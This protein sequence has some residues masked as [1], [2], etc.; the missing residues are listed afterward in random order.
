VQDLDRPGA[1]HEQAHRDSDEGGEASD[2]H[3]E[4]R[5]SE[6]RRVGTRVRLEPAAAG[7]GAREL[8]PAP[9]IGARNGYGGCGSREDV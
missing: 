1:E 9:G 2:P 6:V 5:A 7:K 3:E 8:D 4:A